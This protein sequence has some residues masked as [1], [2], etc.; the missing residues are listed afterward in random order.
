MADIFSPIARM[1]NNVLAEITNSWI[2]GGPA[3]K[4]LR[5]LGSVYA[6]LARISTSVNSTIIE[7][8]AT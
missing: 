2:Y 3:M 6:C 5:L 7:K 4:V 8:K 1:K